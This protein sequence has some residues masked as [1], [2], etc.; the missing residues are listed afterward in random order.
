M[1]T[2]YRFHLDITVEDILKR[3]ALKTGSDVSLFLER[4]SLF[5]DSKKSKPLEKEKT[6][7]QLNYKAVK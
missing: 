2:T 5:P 4:F 3:L 6:L 7:K 1:N